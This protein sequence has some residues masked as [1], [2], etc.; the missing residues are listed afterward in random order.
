[1]DEL[2]N[3]EEIRLDP[4]LAAL[5]AGSRIGGGRF[6]F[7]YGSGFPNPL[8]AN[9]R[10]LSHDDRHPRLREAL[11]FIIK[12]WTSPEPFDWADRATIDEITNEH[13]VEVDCYAD[14]LVTAES[15][16]ADPEAEQL[17]FYAPDV[18]NIAVGWRTSTSGRRS[19]RA[20]IV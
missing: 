6:I 9:E 19:G 20:L 13:C 11:E 1:M 14:V 15:D 18:G 4:A 3:Q 12:C 16:E 7:G 17:K 8:F 10:G 5:A 2:P